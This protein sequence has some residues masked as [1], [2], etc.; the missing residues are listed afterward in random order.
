[1]KKNEKINKEIDLNQ[2]QLNILGSNLAP[3]T[4]MNQVHRS[5][6]A[7]LQNIKPIKTKFTLIMDSMNYCKQ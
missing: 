4:S 1:M 3:S 7:K 2:M 5:K 6:W